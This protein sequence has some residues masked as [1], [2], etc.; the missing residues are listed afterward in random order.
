MKGKFGK[1]GLLGLAVLLSLAAVGVGLAHWQETLTVETTATTGRWKE[2]GGSPGFWKN[3]D[4]HNTYTETEIVG[5]LSAVDASSLWLGGVK[6]I[7]QMQAVLTPV[8]PTPAVPTPGED[9]T[10]EAKFLRQYLAT[11]LNVEAGQLYPELF[12]LFSSY[13]LENYL[14]LGGLGTLEEIIDCIE[15]K[16]GTSPTEDQF[17]IMKNICDAL[18]NLEI[19]AIP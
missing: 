17:E 19:S 9:E 15:S 14:G 1:L 12:H 16:Y 8:V 10:M 4:R 5:F 11:R 6:D 3:W 18:N 7:S 2:V 13:D